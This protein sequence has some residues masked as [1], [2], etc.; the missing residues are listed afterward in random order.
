LNPGSWIYNPPA[1]ASWKSGI[2][3][4]HHCA[5]SENFLGGLLGFEL[6]TLHLC[7]HSSTWAMP[8]ALFAFVCFSDRILILITYLF[9]GLRLPNCSSYLCLLCG[10]DYSCVASCLDWFWNRAWLTFFILADFQHLSFHLHFPCS[11]YYRHT[12]LCLIYKIWKLI[13]I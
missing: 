12:P 5:P 9:I 2:T 13:R 4:L 8:P 10:W 3:D 11:W 6:R 1:S 7:K